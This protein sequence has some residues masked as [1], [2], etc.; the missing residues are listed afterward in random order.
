MVA[1]EKVSAAR[2]PNRSPMADQRPAHRAHQVAKR[3]YAERREQLGDR[4][5]MRK[6]LTADSGCEIAVDRKVVPLQHIAD[7]TG[8]NDPERLRGLHLSA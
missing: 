7:R 1:T 4:V 2:R 5:L 8:G 6:E 3:E